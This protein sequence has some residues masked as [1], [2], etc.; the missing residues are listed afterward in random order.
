MVIRK[1]KTEN[2]W[3][4]GLPA[5]DPRITSY[6][7]IPYADKPVGKNRWR[8]PGPCPDW[9]GERFCAEFGPAA[10]QVGVGDPKKNIYAREWMVDA[11]LPMSEDCL[12]LNIWAPADGRKNMPV[13]VWYHGGSLMAGSTAEMELDGE[14]IARR[15]IVVVTV[16]YRLNCFGFLCHPEITKENPE[17]PANFGF[18]DQLCALK[19]VKR[20]IEAF[21]GDAENITVGG[22]S[23]GG[24]GVCVQMTSPACK[25]LFKRAVI[26][27]GTFL[28]PYHV[29]YLLPARTLEEAETQGRR[30]FEGLGVKTLEEARN[31]DARVIENFALSEFKEYWGE[32][33][34]GVFRPY[35][36]NA[37]M[38]HPE[39]MRCPILIGD[40]S[41]EFFVAPP[42]KTEEALSAFAK[43]KYAEAAESFLSLFAR[44]ADRESIVKDATI[45][46]MDF[47]ILEALK[48]NASAGID[49]KMFVYRFDA[50]IPGWDNPGAFH[51]VDLW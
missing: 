21:G 9:E 8:A 22:Q 11:D 1:A 6:K 10:M 2:G 38:L 26:E 36:A 7:G 18:L 31:L 4:R 51:S 46:A 14:R 32:V 43:E 33:L 42:V 15:G 29:K 35:P 40:T 17:A 19:W 34:D 24:M 50:K 20:N 48:K 5:A 41:N 37:W 45:S 44:P 27:S 49:E 39:R 23:A 3:V 25:G 12:Y 13:Y 47:A 16:G 30:F 28:N